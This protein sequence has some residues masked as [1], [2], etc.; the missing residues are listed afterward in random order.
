MKYDDFLKILDREQEEVKNLFSFKNKGY[1]A[2]DE[3]FY[4]FKETA[5]RV[6]GST[7][8]EDMWKVILVYMDKHMIAL[9]KGLGE[10]EFKERLRDIIVYSYLAIG[11]WEEW[12][13]WKKEW[14][15]ANGI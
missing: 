15:S 7:S 14:E 9:T 12:Q 11:V 5:R 10:R 6:F 8:Y 13:D 2:E 3:V 4:N 1:G